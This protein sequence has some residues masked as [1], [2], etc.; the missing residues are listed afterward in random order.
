LD[1][2]IELVTSLGKAALATASV[3]AFVVGTL[4]LAYGAV[5]LCCVPGYPGE[6]FWQRERILY[7]LVPLCVAITVFTLVAWALIRL[8][9]I[10][11][12][13]MYRTTFWVVISSLAIIWAGTMMAVLLHSGR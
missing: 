12:N 9:R 6:S 8:R 7:G 11:L 1:V 10:N 3:A 13:G 5:M 2:S 4:L